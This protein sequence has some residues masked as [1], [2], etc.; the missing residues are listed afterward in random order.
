MVVEEVDVALHRIKDWMVWRRAAR[1]PPPGVVDQ[2]ESSLR[3]VAPW[4]SEV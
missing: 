2:V 1:R 4:R 3:A